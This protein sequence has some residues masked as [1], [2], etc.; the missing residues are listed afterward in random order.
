MKQIIA[1]VFFIITVKLGFAQNTTVIAIENKVGDKQLVLFDSVYT[2]QFNEPFTVNKFRYYISNVKIVYDNGAK[3]YQPKNY[4]HL[5]NDEFAATKQLVFNQKLNNITS[6]EFL[7]GVDSIKNVSGVQSGDLDPSKGMFWTW[8]TGYIYATLEGQSDSSKA[9]AH[10]FTYHVGGYKKGENA[11]RKVKLQVT[12]LANSSSN[13]LVL[14]ANLL[15]WFNGRKEIKIAQEAV[16]HQPCEFALKLADNYTTMF[17][18][19]YK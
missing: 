13:K 3:T 1:L 14:T 6:I 15:A 10:Y 11:L 12:K 16:C 7:I 8:N 2:N 17:T 9:P 4:Y 18:I 5:V 19:G